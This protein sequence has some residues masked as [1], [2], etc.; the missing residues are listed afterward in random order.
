MNDCLF[1]FFPVGPMELLIV[2]FIMLL[3][4]GSRLPSVMRNLG[5]SA[6]EF[7]KGVDGAEED[8][9]QAAKSVSKDE[10]TE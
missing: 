1:G 4:F 3:L 9:Q 8:L 5:Q 6:R 10:K 2:L 7:K